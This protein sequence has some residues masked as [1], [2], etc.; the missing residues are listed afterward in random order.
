MPVFK[1]NGPPA[2][3]VLAQLEKLLA[4]DIF[5]RADRLGRFLRFVVTHTLEARSEPLK[6]YVIGVEVFDKDDGFDSRIDPIVR[7][8]A[9]RLRS[10]LR[11]YYDGPGNA[12][13]VRIE[14]PKRGYTPSFRYSAPDMS[15]RPQIAD[16]ESGHPEGPKASSLPGKRRS[17]IPWY[18]ATFALAVLLIAGLAYL[19]RGDWSTSIGARDLSSAGAATAKVSIAVLPLEH[20]SGRR[21]DQYYSDAITEAVITQ[22][23]QV[24]PLLV[25]SMKSVQRYRGTTKPMSEIARELNVTHVLGGSVLR[26]GDRVRVSVRLIDGE[27]NRSV[28]AQSYDRDAQDVLAVQRDVSARI[29]RAL[30]GKMWPPQQAAQAAVRIDPD[31]YEDYAKGR[32]FRNQVS[33]DGFRKG[34]DYFRRAIEKQP[35]YAPAYSGMAS[36][37]CLLGG[38]G[39]ELV[40]PHETMSAAK[41][42]A[43]QAL[44]LDESLAEPHAILGIIRTKYDWDWEGAERAF[45]RALELEPSYAQGHTWYSFYLEAMGRHAEAIKEATLAHELNP[46]SLESGVNLAWQFYQTHRY[47]AAFTQLKKTLELSPDSWAVHWALGQYYREKKMYPEAIAALQKST[48]LQGGHTLAKSTLGYTHA[49]AGQ[50]ADAV[51]IVRELEAMSQETYVSPAHIAIIYAGLGDAELAFAWLEKAYLVRARAMAWL[52]VTR[53]WDSLR[54]DPRFAAL[55]RKVGLKN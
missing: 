33:A 34:I 11:E 26:A 4:S 39:L 2:S 18:A 5:A 28:W 14:L 43:L 7:V 22:L 10:K 46:V 37:Y 45:K 40:P 9:G 3:E 47:D 30:T 8:E 20:L 35:K 21:D 24:R 41:E 17:A 19:W 53:E 55:V 51:R 38:H 29:A 27:T 25:I 6:E 31:A 23:S 49:V 54:A 15:A 36:C 42:A 1:L 16:I 48:D 32:F 52:N 44:H 50:T 13:D 12:D